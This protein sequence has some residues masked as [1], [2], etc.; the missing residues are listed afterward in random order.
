MGRI[1]VER[2]DYCD[3]L[4]NIQEDI[5]TLKL[6]ERYSSAKTKDEYYDEVLK[7]TNEAKKFDQPTLN[8]TR[9]AMGHKRSDHS[10]LENKLPAECWKDNSYIRN[11]L[12]LKRFNCIV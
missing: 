3:A 7:R 5:I 10:H 11:R 8:D 6:Y 12:N 1:T 9:E 2:D 4:M